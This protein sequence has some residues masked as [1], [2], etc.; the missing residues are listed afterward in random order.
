M[1]TDPDYAQIIF[2]GTLYQN[3]FSW[4]LS[5]Y[6]Y[7]FMDLSDV[8]EE[9]DDHITDYRLGIVTVDE[10]SAE[11]FL[12]K[13]KAFGWLTEDIRARLFGIKDAEKWGD[14]SEWCPSLLVDFD[15]KA[16]YSIFPEPT[17]FELSAPS[18]WHRSY[19]DFLERV[20]LEHRYW[21]S[22]G[23]DYFKRFY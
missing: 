13:M 22:D 11:L 6:D 12:K 10:N 18:H 8:C 1:Y 17:P 5:E 21:I 7:W 15:N 19:E 4:F 16:F 14:I 20:P 2:V 3:Q 23:D 9:D